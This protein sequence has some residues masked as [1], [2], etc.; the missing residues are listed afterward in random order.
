MTI[1][2]DLVGEALEAGLLLRRDGDHIHID[3][4]LGRPLPKRLRARLVGH[5]AEVLGFLDWRE[6]ADELLLATSRRIAAHY[7][8][9]CP[10]D[11]D[12][13]LA[14]E[15]AL[16]GAHRSQDRELLQE[17]LARYERFALEQFAAYERKAQ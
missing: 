13:W 3:S 4:P 6:S 12:A 5:R 7:P 9:G 16:G 10:L 11:S 8:A 14:A 17:A 2:A 15:E 1:A